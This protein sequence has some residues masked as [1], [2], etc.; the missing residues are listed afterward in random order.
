SRPDLSG[1][2][3]DPSRLYPSRNDRESIVPSRRKLNA[4]VLGVLGIALFLALWQAV[5]TLGLVKAEYLPPPT[6]VAGA[7]VIVLGDPVFWAAL[8]NTLLTWI[9]GLVISLI[10]AIIVG[11]VVGL[12]PAVRRATRT[13]IEFLRPIPSVA[14]IPLAILTYGLQREAALVIVIWATFW[15]IFIQVL[16]GVADVDPVARDTARSFGLGTVA[17]LRYVVLPTALPY[18]STGVRL[19]GTV[20]LVLAVTA[21]LVIGNPGL[22]RLITLAQSGIGAQTTLY[23][24]VVIAGMLGLIINLVLRALERRV[25]SWHHS[26]RTEVL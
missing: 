8:G 9:I 22:G 13:T 12:M 6:A 10:A 16:Y 25:L 18:L 23:A 17:R 11:T 21:E 5:P 26:V 20:A 1:S 2:G 19:G 24:L 14:L 4:A 15:Q 7:I 3:R